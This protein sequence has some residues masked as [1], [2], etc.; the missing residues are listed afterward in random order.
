MNSRERIVA[1]INHKQP[2]KIPFDLGAGSA[3]T[4]HVASME[5]LRDYY[6]LP[7]EPVTVYSAYTMTGHM[8]PAL[9]EKLRTDTMPAVPRSSNFGLLRDRYKIWT[10]PWGQ[11][12]YIS[13]MFEVTPDGK[14]GWYTYPQGDTRCPPSAHMP[15]GSVYFDCIEPEIYLDEDNMNPEDNLE[16]FCVMNEADIAFAVKSVN[17][18]YETG[19]AVVFGTPGTSLGD[20]SLITG[21]NLK[22]PK[23]IRRIEEWYT[24]PLLY[25][26]YV[27]EVFDRQ[28]DIALENLKLLKDACGEKIDIIY[29]CGTDFGHQNNT[30]ISSEVYRQVWMPY[31]Q[32]MAN[33]IHSN[34]K[35]KV[36]KHSCGSVSSLIPDMIESGIDILNPVQTSAA[37][38]DPVMLKREFGKDIVF[39]GGGVDTQRVLPFGTPDEVRKQVLER[40]EIF[41]RD[42][43]FV[44]N[45]IHVVQYDVPL[46]NMVAMIEAVHEFNGE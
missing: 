14:G 23:G 18:A 3:T 17:A 13:S 16:E 9:A 8:T 24:A 34:T 35:W 41:G 38:M 27:T 12:V 19:R 5:K 37:N 10:T 45:P 6:G 29:L 46:E 22:N 28:T 25:P 11:D 39:W 31:Y 32:K 42:G 2:D 15:V 21:S 44:F 20:V 43:G 7:K 4:L 40:C 30:F 36:M 1:S 26:E 33:W